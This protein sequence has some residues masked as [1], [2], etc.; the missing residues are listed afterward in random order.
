MG[1]PYTTTGNLIGIPFETESSV[2]FHWRNSFGFPYS[3]WGKKIVGNRRSRERERTSRVNEWTECSLAKRVKIA[4]RVRFFFTA[5]PSLSL[6]LTLREFSGCLGVERAD[7]LY[8]WLLFF[9]FT[10][11]SRNARH[12]SNVVVSFSLSFSFYFDYLIDGRP[13]PVASPING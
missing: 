4:Q 6:L 10:R 5:A 12:N 13:V 7:D 1:D 3:G 8:F 11:P 2:F 9:C